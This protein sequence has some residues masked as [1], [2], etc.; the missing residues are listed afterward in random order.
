MLGWRTREPIV[1]AV[2]DGNVLPGGGIVRAVL[3]NRGR[4][5]ATWRVAGSGKRRTVELEPFRRLPARAAIAAE[6]ADVGRFLGIEL[7]L[8]S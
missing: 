5:C 8:A 6:A 3:L 2:D 4:A 1:P 7:R